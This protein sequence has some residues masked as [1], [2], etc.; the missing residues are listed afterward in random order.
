MIGLRQLLLALLCSIAFVVGCGGSS[1]P[2]SR[3]A[4]AKPRVFAPNP[5]LASIVRELAGDEVDLATPWMGA[6]DPAF[7]KP[8]ADA[9]RQI[10]S[11]DLILLNGAA[12]EP[13]ASQ[14]ALPRAR[15]VDTTAAV[16]SQLIE[17]AGET[18]SHGPRGEHAHASTASTTWLSPAIARAQADSIAS[19]LMPFF[20]AS[21]AKGAF[22]ARKT[23][24]FA[25]FTRT[26]KALAELKALEPRWLASHPV[27]QYLGQSAGIEIKSKHWEPGE[28]PDE[29]EWTKFRLMRAAFPTPTA[30]M[31]WEGEPG[32]EIRA[33]LEKDGVRVAVVPLFPGADGEFAVSY[34]LLVEKLCDELRRR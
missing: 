29:K 32:P 11:C 16:K 8:T 7:W 10:Q 31:L 17:V 23:T 20:T 34:A 6:P 28:M 30:W 4:G 25:T 19:A 5:A 9:V 13:W 27:Y 26:E 21:E 15:T 2:A 3:A 24:L 22:A 18:H 1:A 12:Y 33:Q 14:A